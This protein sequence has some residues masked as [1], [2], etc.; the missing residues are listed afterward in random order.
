MPSASFFHRKPAGRHFRLTT[1]TQKG[2]AI[3][4]KMV[5]VRDWN[6]GTKDEGGGVGWNLPYLCT[7]IRE[8]DPAVEN[9]HFGRSPD[10]TVF[11]TPTTHYHCATNGANNVRN[12]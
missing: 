4:R 12:V 2:R 9:T 8:I 6:E 7:T 10:Q 5:S 3:G 1:F 11:H